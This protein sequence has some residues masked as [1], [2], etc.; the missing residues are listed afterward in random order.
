MDYSSMY[1]ILTPGMNARNT[2]LIL[3]TKRDCTNYLGMVAILLFTMF[4]YH[5][6]H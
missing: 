2:Q 6:W 1:F 4:E 3:V 5:V